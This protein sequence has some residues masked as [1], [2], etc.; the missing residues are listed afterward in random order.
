MTRRSVD[1]DDIARLCEPY[2]QLRGSFGG[3][4]LGG[5]S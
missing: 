1:L 5:P 4:A 2:A 3:Q